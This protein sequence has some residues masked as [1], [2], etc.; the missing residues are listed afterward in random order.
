MMNQYSSWIGTSK[1]THLPSPPSIQSVPSLLPFSPYFCANPLFRYGQRPVWTGSPALSSSKAEAEYLALQQTACTECK[2][3]PET[4]E[5]TTTLFSGSTRQDQ[6]VTPRVKVVQ[7]AHR[8]FLFVTTAFLLQKKP[9]Q[10]QN[11]P[12]PSH[13]HCIPSPFFPAGN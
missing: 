9:P 1:I 7:S 2:K 3:D 8:L 11:K 12:P 4:N 5:D 10:T 13:S 6:C